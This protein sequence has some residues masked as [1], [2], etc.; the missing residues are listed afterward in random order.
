MDRESDPGS[1]EYEIEV[2]NTTFGLVGDIFC[3]K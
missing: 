3:N 2:I 1:T